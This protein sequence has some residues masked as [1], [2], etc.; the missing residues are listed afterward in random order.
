MKKILY[1]CL[2]IIVSVLLLPSEL[3]AH[4][5]KTD[6]SGCHTC[7]TNCANWGLSVGEYHCHNAKALPQPK[8]PIRS[9]YGEGGTGTTE[10]WPEYAAPSYSNE[11]QKPNV[12]AEKYQEPK[13]PA[14]TDAEPTK[15]E[16][17]ISLEDIIQE[18]IQPA[19]LTV[20]QEVSRPKRHWFTR[21][22]SFI[23]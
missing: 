11:V 18:E 6:A 4:P 7:R 12:P 2:V 23:F 16:P 8:A 10:P 22:L 14:T 17:A 1:L 3:Y 19:V 20:N 5:G 15:T 21:L 9:H 13:I